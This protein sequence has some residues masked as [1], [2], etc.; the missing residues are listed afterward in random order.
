[1][2]DVMESALAERVHRLSDTTEILEPTPVPGDILEG[3]RE[4]L[5]SGETH[6]TARPGLPELRQQIAG[7]LGLADRTLD[8]VVITSGEREALFV[9]R[10][11]LGLDPLFPQEDAS[12]VVLGADPFGEALEE[13]TPST[14]LVATLDALPGL[15]SFRVGFVCAPKELAPRIRT[16]KQ[17]LSICTAAPSQRAALL[18]LSR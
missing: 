14:T 12:L 17:A 16:W 6:Y 18:A 10:L 3:V 8:E 2:T 7:R 11:A 13:L 1:M 4:A 15:A 5:L 9:A